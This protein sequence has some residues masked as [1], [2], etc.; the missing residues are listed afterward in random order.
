MAG[1]KQSQK[2]YG[3]QYLPRGQLSVPNYGQAQPNN[4]EYARACSHVSQQLRAQLGDKRPAWDGQIPGFWDGVPPQQSH[5][6]NQQNQRLQPLTNDGQ[7]QQQQYMN[8]DET[9]RSHF[10]AQ[11]HFR[12]SQLHQGGGG[13]GGAN[14]GSLP[15]TG[16]QQASG[17]YA[18]P[19]PN[20]FARGQPG[21][22]GQGRS[23]HGYAPSQSNAQV[24]SL[25]D[26][27]KS[28]WE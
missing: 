14:L 15:A 16:M 2:G 6:M 27:D 24:I 19:G 23:R 1:Q 20:S 9:S 5:T 8:D 12:A 17:K 7:G 28:R 10:T 11:K 3:N 22:H 13:H 18:M 21:M 25:K 4:E 26:S